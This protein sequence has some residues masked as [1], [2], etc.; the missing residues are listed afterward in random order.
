MNV[1]SKAIDPPDFVSSLR[2]IDR[3]T[4]SGL[5][6]DGFS[7][8]VISLRELRCYRC[9]FLVRCSGVF[10]RVSSYLICG[11]VGFLIYM[12]AAVANQLETRL[13]AEIEYSDNVLNLVDDL[14]T[15][16]FLYR[17]SIMFDYK[18]DYSILDAHLDYSISPVSY[19]DDS[20]PARTDIIGSAEVELTIVDQRFSWILKQTGNRFL[21]DQQLDDN[22]VN[23][24]NRNVIK[25]GPKLKQK[26]GNYQLN[27][28]VLQSQTSFGNDDFGVSDRTSYEVL[29][30]RQ[31]GRGLTLGITANVTDVE[32]QEDEMRAYQSERVG[33]SLNWEGK[34]LSAQLQF[35]PSRVDRSSGSSTMAPFVSLGLTRTGRSSEWTLFANNQLTD[36]ATGLSGDGLT[37]DALNNG[38]GNFDQSEVIERSRVETHYRLDIIPGKFSTTLTASWDSQDNTDSGDSNRLVNGQFAFSYQ[39]SPRTRFSFSQNYQEGRTISALLVARNERFSLSNSSIL[40][41]YN[42]NRK[43]SLDL[44]FRLISRGSDIRPEWKTGQITVAWTYTL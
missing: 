27:L 19:H 29:L 11:T 12:P 41:N 30:N 34:H 7:L 18:L 40:F 37:Q 8:E 6:K 38:D 2:S 22:P 9:S 31:F 25:T 36:S 10:Q 5:K 13:R 23:Q 24:I 33:F 20:F 28:E 1:D 16:D 43:S 39:F 32:F 3:H 14:A 21:V 15:S 35:G 17:P 44:T 42:I 26:L 4:A